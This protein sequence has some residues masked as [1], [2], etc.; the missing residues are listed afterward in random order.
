MVGSCM[1]A[2]VLVAAVQ[3]KA[4]EQ[5]E[6]RDLWNDHHCHL[7][8]HF[9]PVGPAESHGVCGEKVSSV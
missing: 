8:L 4:D 7:T 2:R 1:M 5:S 9:L 3:R 6:G